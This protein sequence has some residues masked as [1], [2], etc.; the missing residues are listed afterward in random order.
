[1]AD[2]ELSSRSEGSWFCNSIM[3]ED[4]GVTGNEWKNKQ[5]SSQRHGSGSR[6]GI[7]LIVVTEIKW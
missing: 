1:M 4:D 5:E 7:K 2:V 6:E 3:I